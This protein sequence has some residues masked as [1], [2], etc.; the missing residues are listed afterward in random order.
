MRKQIPIFGAG[1]AISGYIRR[2][3]YEGGI[4]RLIKKPSA[5]M[6]R[7]YGHLANTQTVEPYEDNHIPFDYHEP[8][9]I[10]HNIFGDDEDVDFNVGVIRPKKKPPK[11]KNKAP[12]E[13]EEEKQERIRLTKIKN[14]EYERDD[15]TLIKNNSHKMKIKI[16]KEN[17]A[18]HNVLKDV[19]QNKEK[20]KTQQKLELKEKVI[21]KN[22]KNIAKIKAEFNDVIA[23][24]KL[25]KLDENDLNAVHNH[26]RMKIKDLQQQINSLA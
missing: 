26:A 12:T 18:F 3:E 4:T 23:Y 10:N 25:N 6:I 16:Q 17:T 20:L 5:Y 21:A 15:V 22:R 8:T 14:L 19:E 9:P 24:I 2:L 13:A 1:N 7:K 11:N